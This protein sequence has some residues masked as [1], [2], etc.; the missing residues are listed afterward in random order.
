VSTSGHPRPSSLS[1]RSEAR[2]ERAAG[3]VERAGRVAQKESRG[4]RMKERK[5]PPK[6]GAA[7]DAM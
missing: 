7:Q 6:L 1:A 4:V 2:G 3:T 5:Q